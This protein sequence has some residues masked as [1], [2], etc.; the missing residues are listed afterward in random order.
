S[1]CVVV[2]PD[3]LKQL[4]KL[5]DDV[6][7]FNEAVEEALHTKYTNITS[8]IPTIP[9]T[10]KTSLNPALFR[11]NPIILDEITQAVRTEI[12]PSQTWTPVP[13]NKKLA[14]IVAQTSGRIFVG[15]DL[16]RDETY[17]DAAVNY[18]LDMT[19]AVQAV[20]FVSPWLRPFLAARTPQVRKLHDRFRHADEFLRP[21]VTARRQAAREGDEKK[22]RHDDM[23]QWL[24]DSQDRFGEQSDRQISKYQLS[25]TFAAIHT[26]TAALTNAFYDLAARPE[27]VPILREEIEEVIA[28]A[29]GQI[30]A[31]AIQKM[32]KL[33]SFLKEIMRYYPQ[34]ATAFQRKVMKP[35]TLPN[36]RTVPAGVII[37][38]PSHAVNNDES[39]YAHPETFDALRFYRIRKETEAA[40][41]GTLSPDDAATGAAAGNQFASVTETSL[42]FGYGRNACPGRFLAANEIKMILATA[43]LEYDVALPPGCEGRY[44]NLNFGSQSVPDPTKS[45]M[46]RKRT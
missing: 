36:G 35:F 6:L 4:K 34:S 32:V 17:L 38:V 26:T 8:N 44:E 16:C 22:G 2:P 41:S 5:P 14:R 45:I 23:L 24:L 20:G 12:P 3:F 29:G 39:I 46:M 40:L 21:V 7:S 28:E 18:T 27:L 15:P 43:L 30:T 37:E 31:A 10:L 1:E 19:A 9:H 42:A 13:I 25:L 33:D 11:L